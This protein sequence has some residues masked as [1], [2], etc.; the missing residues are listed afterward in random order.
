MGQLGKYEDINESEEYGDTESPPNLG[1][2]R[3]LVEEW[4]DLVLEAQLLWVE[5]LADS[6]PYEEQGKVEPIKRPRGRPKGSKNKPKPYV[7][8]WLEQYLA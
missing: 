5:V 2:R 7:R 1:H 8:A 6:Q 4:D 3:P